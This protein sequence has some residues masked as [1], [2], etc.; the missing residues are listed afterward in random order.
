[1]APLIE[2][3]RKSK[4]EEGKDKKATVA[5][6]G[7]G[8]NARFSNGKKGSWKN[9]RPGSKMYKKDLSPS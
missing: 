9:D 2:Q 7:R 8:S 6:K 1:M 3:E 5:R 4:K